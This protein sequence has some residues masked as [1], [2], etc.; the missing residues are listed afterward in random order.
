MPDAVAPP[1][2]NRRFPLLDGMR[3]VAVLCV[4]GVHVA[5][6]SDAGTGIARDLLFHLNIGVTIFFLISGFVLYRPFIVHRVGGPSAPAPVQYAKRRFLRIVPA[7]WLAL[8]VLTIL[9]G[10]I[11]V[12]GGDWFSQYALLHTLSVTGDQSCLTSILDCGLAQTWSLVVEVTFYA[13]LPLYALIAARLARGRSPNAWLSAELILLALFAIASVAIRFGTTAGDLSGVTAGTLAGYLLWFGLGM[14]LALVSVWLESNEREPGW[15]RLI[16]AHPSL[17]W[18]L[19]IAIYVA[20]SLALPATPFL[21]STSQQF[22]LHMAFAA[23][24]LLLMLPAVFGDRSGGLP[25]RFLANPVVAR[26]GLISYGIFLWHYVVTIELGFP[27][28]GLGFPA[29]L[30]ATLAISIAVATASYY[31]LERPLL[32]LKRGGKES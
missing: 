8:T 31:L 11:G 20:I 19:A 3:A 15:V 26:L 16:A 21:L 1:P 5:V 12:S 17:P 6:F 32:R 25:R 7:Y 10:I 4:V 2:G 22:T 13:A 24:A 29:L 27:G 18:V 9:P 28:E 14:G 30:A 23:V